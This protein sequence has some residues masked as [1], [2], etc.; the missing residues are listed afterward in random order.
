MDN[1]GS[2]TDE[3]SSSIGNGDMVENTNLA[4]R[5]TEDGINNITEISSTIDLSEKH[6][7]SLDVMNSEAGASSSGNEQNGRTYNTRLIYDVMSQKQNKSQKIIDQQFEDMRMEQTSKSIEATNQKLGSSTMQ[8]FSSNFLQEKTY[9]NSS[10]QEAVASISRLAEMSIGTG[11]HFTAAD[12]KEMSRAIAS[13]A[14]SVVNYVASKGADAISQ[15]DLGLQALQAISSESESGYKKLLT[16]KKTFSQSFGSRISEDNYNKEE[17]ESISHMAKDSKKFAKI[18]QAIDQ[19]RDVN[20]I[21]DAMAILYRIQSYALQQGILDTILSNSTFTITENNIVKLALDKINESNV[22]WEQTLVARQSL[23]DRMNT[24]FESLKRGITILQR[25]RPVQDDQYDGDVQEEEDVELRSVLDG[26]GYDVIVNWGSKVYSTL[27][28]KLG[29]E[30]YVN[31]TEDLR[32]ILENFKNT[33]NQWIEA[34]VN[35]GIDIVS[36]ILKIPDVRELIGQMFSSVNNGI[37]FQTNDAY[38]I[39]FPVMTPTLERYLRITADKEQVPDTVSLQ[40][41]QIAFLTGNRVCGIPTMIQPQSQ[42]RVKINPNYSEDVPLFDALQFL[43]DLY[44]TKITLRYVQGPDALFVNMGGVWSSLILEQDVIQNLV[45]KYE[46]YQLS[47]QQKI[48]SV[49]TS[50]VSFQLFK[51][52]LESKVTDHISRI[53]EGLSSLIVQKLSMLEHHLSNRFREKRG[54]AQV[55]KMAFFHYFA[56]NDINLDLLTLTLQKPKGTCDVCYF[57]S[58][59]KKENQSQITNQYFRL[60]TSR[61]N[62]FINDLILLTPSDKAPHADFSKYVYWSE[63]HDHDTQSII[64][65]LPLGYRTMKVRYSYSHPHFIEFNSLRSFDY[66]VGVTAMELGEK[67]RTPDI[68]INRETELVFKTFHSDLYDSLIPLLMLPVSHHLSFQTK[69]VGSVVE[70]S[71]L[72]S[73]SMGN[74]VISNIRRVLDGRVLPI[75]SFFST[76]GLPRRFDEFV[77]YVYVGTSIVQT[78]FYHMPAFGTGYSASERIKLQIPVVLLEHDVLNF[79]LLDYGVEVETQYMRE[80]LSC[81]ISDEFE[82]CLID[83]SIP[84][85]IDRVEHKIV[86][87]HSGN[88]FRD[89]KNAIAGYIKLLA[90]NSKNDFITAMCANASIPKD[91]Y[92]LVYALLMH[93][94]YYNAGIKQISESSLDLLRA[95]NSKKLEVNKDSKI[96]K[97]LLTLIDMTA[98]F[99]I[100]LGDKSEAIIAA[101]KASILDSDCR[102]FLN[103]VLASDKEPFSID[104]TKVSTSL[105]ENT[106]PIGVNS[107]EHVP[108]SGE[109]LNKRFSSSVRGITHPTILFIGQIKDDIQAL[110]L[111][112]MIDESKVETEGGQNVRGINYLRGYE[113]LKYTGYHD[114]V[115]CDINHS[116]RPFGVNASRTIYKSILSRARSVAVFKVQSQDDEI[117]S[118][119]IDLAKE[120]NF[121]ENFVLRVPTYGGYH[122]ETHLIF[123]KTSNNILDGSIILPDAITKSVGRLSYLTQLSGHSG[124][125][126]D[127]EKDLTGE[128]FKDLSGKLSRMKF[129]IEDYELK[130]FMANPQD[131]IGRYFIRQFILDSTNANAFYLLA[132][133]F[134]ARVD[135]TCVN[136]TSGLVRGSFLINWRSIVWYKRQLTANSVALPSTFDFANFFFLEDQS[137]YEFKPRPFSISMSQLKISSSINFMHKFMMHKFIASKS[138]LKIFDIGA[139]D[140]FFKEEHSLVTSMLGIKPCDIHYYAIDSKPEDESNVDEY[141]LTRK[142]FTDDT[143]INMVINS[144]VVILSNFIMNLEPKLYTALMLFLVVIYKKIVIYNGFSQSAWFRNTNLHMSSHIIPYFNDNRLSSSISDLELP[145]YHLNGRLTFGVKEK[146]GNRGELVLDTFKDYFSD[147]AELPDGTKMNDLVFFNTSPAC[148]PEQVKWVNEQYDLSYAHHM[149]NLDSHATLPYFANC[150]SVMRNFAIGVELK[151]S[152]PDLIH[153]FHYL[154][155]SKLPSEMIAYLPFWLRAYPLMVLVPIDEKEKITDIYFDNIDSF[156]TSD[157]SEFLFIPKIAD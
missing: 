81:S 152:Q 117:L 125:I 84:G 95:T 58:L 92:G 137:A 4:I 110:R 121:V 132:C 155:R 15:D 131:Y 30:R 50:P 111:N 146:K 24:M 103:V 52:S 82:H 149:Y 112:L 120:Y 17:N 67:I 42:L 65:E 122:K 97:V 87:Y 44:S 6:N 130:D 156:T 5:I 135:L 56:K 28:P 151:W 147:D 94:G 93:Y 80:E 106:F 101:A 36:I 31:H 13:T 8:L 77:E 75:N 63:T 7:A 62:F 79:S 108:F 115:I 45:Y 64:D 129:N 136:S 23:L 22:V 85:D 26:D 3:S 25:D 34:F 73:K 46:M 29:T 148:V 114:I 105:I 107:F 104:D 19:L 123:K 72:L 102:G 51:A 21:D 68:S 157:S 37:L 70:L 49:N 16:M 126:F 89:S 109:T 133:Q 40:Y 18:L 54:L 128:R 139:R 83:L 35:S 11:D 118:E 90:K 60:K 127:A 10:K 100:T 116:D 9:T 61:Y 59:L 88:S 144:D 41:L 33:Y 66:D 143:F 124:F 71:Q 12:M 38:P 99:Q 140:G 138:E 2:S 119:I 43:R 27:E 96:R 141:T 69:T 55:C 153:V 113:D 39:P 53:E 47:Q 14:N 154:L 78:S 91:G 32:R 57:I 86:K 74:N 150:G 1:D 145:A 134:G 48:S 142:S 76:L 98:I 20:D